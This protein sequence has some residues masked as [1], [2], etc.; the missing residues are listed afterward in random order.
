LTD[1]GIAICMEGFFMLIGPL[2]ASGSKLVK[3]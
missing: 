1:T 2:Q 3:P